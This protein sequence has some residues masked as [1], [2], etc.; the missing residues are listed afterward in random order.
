MSTNDFVKFLTQQFVRYVDQP[1][2][3]RVEKKKERKEQKP[4]LSVKWFG[5]LPMA[6]SMLIRRK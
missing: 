2:K 6:I 1:K 4:P 3:D 5:L